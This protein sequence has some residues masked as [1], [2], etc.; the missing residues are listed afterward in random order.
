MPDRLTGRT[1][2]IAT[3]HALSLALLEDGRLA[4]RH[5]EPID[6]G[7]AERLV[8]ALA[9]LLNDRTGTA[10]PC[11]R[12]LFEVGPGSF[13][14]LRV[15]AA[16][17]RAL[18]LAWGARLAGVRSTVLVAARARSLGI[19]GPLAVALKAPRGQ[20]WLEYFSAGGCS[21]LGPPVALPVGRLPDRHG[22]AWVGNA[23]PGAAT[24]LLVPEAASVACL[25]Q[26]DYSPPDLLYVR[27]AGLDAAA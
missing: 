2:A 4:A 13:T 8:P 18:A 14:G 12:I 26:A 11:D 16:A 19:D 24:E 25:A 22:Y 7:H 21:S 15:G 23:I 10:V 27:E 5:D 17:A 20:I 9:R 1:L 6:R 3:G